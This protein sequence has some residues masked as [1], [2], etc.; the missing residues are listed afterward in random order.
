MRSEASLTSP[1]ARLGRWL[2]GRPRVVLAVFAAIV[3]VGGVYGSSVA[4]H[5][6]AGGADVS[7][8][9]SDRAAQAGERYFGIGAPDVLVLY[10][11][12]N[13][14]VRDALFGSRIFDLLD[15]VLADPG[16]V[17]AVTYYDTHQETLVSLDGRDT[18]VIVSLA[19]DNA[20]KIETYRRIEP[21]LRA[22]DPSVGVEIGGTIAASVLA[23][24]LARRDVA[25]AEAV[26]LPIALLLTGLFFR[27][28]VAALLP[29]AIGIFALDASS[30]L[31]RL[32]TNFT[33]ISIFAMNV[34]VFLGLG[35][36][37]DYALLLVQRFREELGR[38]LPVRDAV[39]TTLDTAGRAVWVSGLTVAV[40]LAALI[41]VSLPILRSVAIGGVLVVGSA[42]TGALVLL[43]AL[44]AWLGPAVNRWPLGRAPERSGPSPFWQRV[45]EFSMRHPFVTV[46]GCLL[47]LGALAS[48]VLRMRSAIPD[49]RMFAR[50]SEV[51]RVDEALGDPKRFDPGGAS[52]MQI[53]VRTPGSPLDPANLRRVRAYVARLDAVPGVDS[54]KTPLADLDPDALDPGALR[55]KA[56]TEPLLSELD[57]L[58][59]QDVTLLIAANHY[60]WRSREASDVVEAVRRVPHP[61][62]EVLVGGATAAMVDLA[63]TLAEFEWMAV[64]LVASWNLLVL[65]GAFRSLVVPVKAVVMNLVSLG[66]SYG[67]LV[68]VFQEGHGSGLLGFEPLGGIDPT[69]PLVMYAVV[70]G[71]SMDYEVF[72]LSRIQEEWRR[73]GDNRAS[74]IAGLAHTGRIITS[75]ALI[76]LVVVGAFAAGRL[77]YVKEIGVGMAAAIALDVTVVRALLVPATMQLLGRWNWWAP[78]WM[79]RRDDVGA[80]AVAATEAI[81][82]PR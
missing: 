1:F 78:R 5:L 27:S 61:G 18:L 72:L 17:G 59:K 68:W 48:P 41:P 38:G 73:T 42:L 49:A 31:M 79:R 3:V 34:C 25:A 55:R 47:V 75:A 21:Q 30:A 44:L 26:A 4:D 32:G 56:S 29:I 45:G 10:R 37:I 24:Q 39:G 13:G 60:P 36:S 62:L 64:L 80:T 12:R 81:G 71:L 54:V 22:V 28:V 16:V 15:P 40:S 70:F 33:E 82:S 7:G 14:D 77:V 63:Q 46:A 57:H 6:P 2:A 43:P 76:L 35:L 11:N 69:I 67:L 58:V 50:D 53:V 8:S 65:L 23:Q 52:A 74:V 20:R 66:A 51:R 9:E 19:G